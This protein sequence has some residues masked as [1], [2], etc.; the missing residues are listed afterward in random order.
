LS[1]IFVLELLHC[2]IVF[3]AGAGVKEDMQTC[4][5][6]DAE[7]DA[8][9]DTEPG[10]EPDMKPGAEPDA[11]PVAEPDVD[12][13]AEPDTAVCMTGVT[14]VGAGRMVASLVEDW[15]AG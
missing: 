6:V 8:E 4:G 10:A 11:E 15:G 7:P 9:P 3:S 1:P 14:A 13:G 5:V 12:P 2:G